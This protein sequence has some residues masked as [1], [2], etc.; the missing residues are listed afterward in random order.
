MNLITNSLLLAG[1]VALLASCG[2]K[3]EEAVTEPVQQ[4]VTRKAAATPVAPVTAANPLDLF[5]TPKDDL[6][7]P[8]ATQLAEGKESSIGTG[9]QS[10]SNPDSRPS[11][12]ITPQVAPAPAPAPEKTPTPPK[13][14]LDPQ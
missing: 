9:I 10:V 7:L 3:E 4:P 11:V 13:D 8:D 14:E 1:L 12:A 6:N 5:H 2:N